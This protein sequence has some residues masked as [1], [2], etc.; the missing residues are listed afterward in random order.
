MLLRSFVTPGAHERPAEEQVAHG[1]PVA[2]LGPV[3]V[4]LD[5][6][7]EQDDGLAIGVFRLLLRFRAERTAQSMV[8]HRKGTGVLIGVRVFCRQPLKEGNRSGVER[9]RR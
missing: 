7:P 4:V 1:Q 3:E 9:L 8:G 2:V 5:Q 6:L